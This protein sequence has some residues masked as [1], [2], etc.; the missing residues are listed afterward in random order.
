M[1]IINR[2]SQQYFPYFFGYLFHVFSFCLYH[3]H[4][5]KHAFNS[6]NS[7][8]IN[9]KSFFYDFNLIVF[10]GDT[11]FCNF[12]RRRI[13]CYMIRVSS[14]WVK[15]PST[16]SFGYFNF[17]TNK[18]NNMTY[19]Y[20]IVQKLGLKFSSWESIKDVVLICWNRFQMISQKFT[21]NFI[22][23]KMTRLSE[24]FYLKPYLTLLFDFSSYQIA[25]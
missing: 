1:C 12:F 22:R 13:H 11:P 14:F 21:H 2:I 18:F 19:F 20:L 9:V 5:I 6:S 25:S 17:I 15:K 7:T 24:F 10:S 8:V 23:S 3:L 4:I 16:K